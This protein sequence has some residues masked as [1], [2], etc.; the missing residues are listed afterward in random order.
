[1]AVG[2]A[3]MVI[4]SK[5]SVPIGAVPITLQ[6]FAVFMCSLIIGWKASIVFLIYAALGLIGL[7]V[8][9]SGGGFAY[10]YAPSFGFIISFI[11]FLLFNFL[12]I[13]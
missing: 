7:P 8:F 6:T 2:L 10:V 13:S 9:S 11:P 3:L 1:M 5:V 4:C 12:I